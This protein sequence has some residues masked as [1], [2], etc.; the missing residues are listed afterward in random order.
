LSVPFSCIYLPE[1]PD[2]KTMKKRLVFVFIL[3]SLAVP[4]LWNQPAIS[5]LQEKLNMAEESYRPELLTQIAWEYRNSNP[6]KSIEFGKQAIRESLLQTDL[7][8]LTKAYGFVGVAYRILGNYS[9]AMDYF[10][11]GLELARK[12]GQYEQE[13]YALINIAN[14]HIYQEFYATALANLKL[15]EEIAEAEDNNRMRS[16]VYL[17]IGRAL[18]LKGDFQ[19]ALQYLTKSLELRIAKGSEPEQ[20]VNY[21]YIAD[22]YLELGNFS[23]ALVNYQTAMDILDSEADKDLAANVLIKIAEAY[24]QTGRQSLAL[25]SALEGNALAQQIGARLP[26]REAYRIL[27]QI[28]FSRG[29]YLKAA[30]SRAMLVAYSDTLFNQKLSEKLFNLQ[31]KHEKELKEAEIELLSKDNEIKKLLL[32]RSRIIAWSLSISLLLLIG[33]TV[34]YLKISSLRKEQN[35]LLRAQKED[36]IKANQTK[37]KMFMIISHDLRGPVGSLIPLLH[38]ISNEPQIKKDIKL[39]ELFVTLIR[40]VQS[41]NDLLENLLYW[42]KNQEG[43]FKLNLENINLNLVVERALILYNGIS[44]AKQITVEPHL[45]QEFS[46]HADRQVMMLVVRNLLSNALK[47]TPDGGLIQISAKRTDRFVELE[48]NDSGIGFDKEIAEKIFQPETRVSM[49]GTDHEEGSGLGLVICKEFIERSGGKIWAESMPGKGSRF[50][51]K[52][53]AAI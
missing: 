53:P 35:T 23:L 3:Y 36:L 20:A 5:L 50:F 44:K 14:L 47:F 2:L 30:E 16:Y 48:V 18:S 46:I 7:E 1:F 17:N 29:D 49:P 13:G 45:Q 8:N 41:V 19:E 51:I 43:E 24:M 34:F 37:D 31:F 25:K 10:Y 15:A 4:Y 33:L 52:I 32:S 21:K 40:S 38:V 6:E 26:V 42:A 22:V 39:Y 9:E 28:Y 27:S 11:Q 12:H